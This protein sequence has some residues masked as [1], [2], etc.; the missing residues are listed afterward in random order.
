MYKQLV[1]KTNIKINQRDS[2]Q[3]IR[4]IPY[5]TNMSIFSQIFEILMDEKK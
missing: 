3:D 2:S 5:Y 4:R 1:T